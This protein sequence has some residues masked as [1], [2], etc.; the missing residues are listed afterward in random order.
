M[1]EAKKAAPAQ[2]PAKAVLTPAGESSDP[3]VHAL[4]AK[5]QAALSNGDE[6]TAVAVDAQLAELG[7]Q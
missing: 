4:L 1:A 7:Y 6:A 3:T 5:R 2:E